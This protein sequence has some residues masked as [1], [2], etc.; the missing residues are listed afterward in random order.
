MTNLSHVV[1]DFAGR[2]IVRDQTGRSEWEVR[3]PEGQYE[4]WALPWTSSNEHS[5]AGGIELLNTDLESLG[6]DPSNQSEELGFR[7]TMASKVRER[8]Q[9]PFK[10]SVGEFWIRVIKLRPILLGPT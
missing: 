8:N 1:K 4:P 6:V 10:L 7:L 2:Y 9:V 5:D 3:V